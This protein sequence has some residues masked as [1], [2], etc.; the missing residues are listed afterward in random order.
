MQIQGEQKVATHVWSFLKNLI[1]I[2]DLTTFLERE[3]SLHHF[4]NRFVIHK[5]KQMVTYHKKHVS[6]LLKT[7]CR[8]I[9]VLCFLNH[10][11]PLK[12]KYLF[13]LSFK[14]L[15]DIKVF[16]KLCIYVCVSMESIEN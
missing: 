7:N 8:I 12:H 1:G 4:D 10:I 3:D 15:C 13:D 9:K 16:S 5:L 14:A 6:V 11:F 2:L